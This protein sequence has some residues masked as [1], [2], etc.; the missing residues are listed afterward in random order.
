MLARFLRDQAWWRLDS[1]GVK[2]IRAARSVVALL[3][4]AICLEG[5]PDNHPDL[6]KLVRA[7]C[8]RDGVFDPG[9]AGLAVVRGWELA[10]QPINPHQDLLAILAFTVVPQVRAS[11]Q[12]PMAPLEGV[13]HEAAPRNG[14]PFPS[15]PRRG[16]PPGGPFLARPP[17][18]RVPPLTGAGAPCGR[19]AAPLGQGARFRPRLSRRTMRQ[20]RPIHVHGPSDHATA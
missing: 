11:V 13:C 20:S 5:L 3:D 1:P 14:V 9:E 18:G 4:T 7:G 2:A 12:V 17:A 10:D 16:P 8:F 6:E 15:D 19:A